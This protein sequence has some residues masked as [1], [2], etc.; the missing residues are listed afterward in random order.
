MGDITANCIPDS[1]IEPVGPLMMGTFDIGTATPVEGDTITLST[2]WLGVTRALYGIIQ[3]G[4]GVAAVAIPC[5]R[6]NAAVLQVGTSATS[7]G[8]TTGKLFAIAEA[9]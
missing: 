8:G 4:T 2:Y 5:T 9:P 7:G 6:K 1:S 3:S